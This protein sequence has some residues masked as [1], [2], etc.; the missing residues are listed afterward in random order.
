MIQTNFS[1]ALLGRYGK[2]GLLLVGTSPMR[3]GTGR[4]D[5]KSL[6]CFPLDSPKKIALVLV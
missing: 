3:N 6:T 2:H 4:G 1:N 5:A